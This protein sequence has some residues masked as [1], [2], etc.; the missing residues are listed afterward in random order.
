[1]NL[2][3]YKYIILNTFSIIFK[4]YYYLYLN[5]FSKNESTIN[6]KDINII[7]NPIIVVKSIVPSINNDPQNNINKPLPKLFLIYGKFYN[8]TFHG[9]S[10]KIIFVAKMKNPILYAITHISTDTI[11]NDNN[12]ITNNKIADPNINPLVKYLTAYQSAILL[13]NIKLI[14]FLNFKIFDN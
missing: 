6:I 3:L 5:Y 13:L 11:K 4:Y 10:H 7:T 1:M 2:Y 12:V 8:A 14:I 9:I